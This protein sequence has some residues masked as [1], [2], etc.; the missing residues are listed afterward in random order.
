MN[1]VPCIPNNCS[2]VIPHYNYLSIY[3][4]LC[5]PSIKS[6]RIGCLHLKHGAICTDSWISMWL[7]VKLPVG[8]T[9]AVTIGM[10]WGRFLGITEMDT[11]KMCITK[12][13]WS[14][15]THLY[16]KPSIK[17]SMHFNTW[18]WEHQIAVYTNWYFD[19][20]IHKVYKIMNDIMLMSLFFLAVFI[21]CLF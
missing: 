19:S 9:S 14:S 11:W 21:Q 1:K 8:L 6:F 5:L 20:V 4:T 16:I 3:N 12:I 18:S 7:V 2:M 15:I 10:W 17:P 13:Y